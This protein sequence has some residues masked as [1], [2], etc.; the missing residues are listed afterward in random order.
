[1]LSEPAIANLG[2]ARLQRALTVLVG[3]GHL[4]PCLPA[5][6][7]GKRVEPP[8][9]STKLFCSVRRTMANCSIWPRP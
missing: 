2:W 3:V 7:E 5:K 8:K 1:M 9:P 6:D 4:Q